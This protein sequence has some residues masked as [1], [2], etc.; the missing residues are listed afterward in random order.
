VVP[1]GHPF[2]L[3]TPDGEAFEALAVA[4]VGVRATVPPGP[5]IA[6]PWIE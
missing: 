1:P 3:G 4:P 5:A 2:S 6:P